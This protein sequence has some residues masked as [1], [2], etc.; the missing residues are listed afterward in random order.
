M[1]VCKHI[2]FYYFLYIKRYSFLE[3]YFLLFAHN[4]KITYAN[5]LKFDIMEFKLNIIVKFSLNKTTFIL[6]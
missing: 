2:L 5:Y 4:I 1:Y 6:K 3:Y